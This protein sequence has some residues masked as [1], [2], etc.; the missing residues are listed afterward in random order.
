M[1]HFF[2]ESNQIAE[3]NITIIGNDVNHINNV[4]RMKIGELITLSDRCDSLEYVCNISEF[5]SDQISCNIIHKAIADTK[6]SSKIYLL[7]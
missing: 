3:Q 7:Q 4:L 2:V 1:Y 5:L 6:L